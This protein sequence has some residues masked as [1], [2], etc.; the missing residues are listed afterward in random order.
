MADVL[1]ALLLVAAGCTTG[2]APQPPST[3]SS[4]T[5]L[6]GAF[7]LPP[8]YSA[9]LVTSQGLT[10]QRRPDPDGG[11]PQLAVQVA[12]AAWVGKLPARVWI[13][14]SQREDGVNLDPFRLGVKGTQW[15]VRVRDAYA[16]LIGA[17]PVYGSQV[18]IPQGRQIPIVDDVDGGNPQVVDVDAL[19]A[20]AGRR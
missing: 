11:P 19:K 2:P 7:R 5:K 14:G 9:G 3:A 6:S 18:L 8:G 1:L 16:E 4:G 12:G 13:R 15:V 17:W 20:R 10:G